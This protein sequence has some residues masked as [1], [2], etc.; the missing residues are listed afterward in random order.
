MAGRGGRQKQ[1][2]FETSTPPGNLE[3]TVTYGLFASADRARKEYNL[4]LDY[5]YEKGAEQCSQSVLRYMQEEILSEG[6]SSCFVAAKGEHLDIWWIENG[7]RRVS[8]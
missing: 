7:S 8:A 6:A 2:E 3:S 4:D 5:E 1:C